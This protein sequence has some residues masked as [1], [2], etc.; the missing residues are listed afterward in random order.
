MI[1]LL[2][3]QS[4]II[5]ASGTESILLGNYEC[6]YAIGLLSKLS[7]IHVSEERNDMR[8]VQ[9]EFCTKLKGYQTTDEKE[10]QLIKILCAYKAEETYDAQMEELF[11]WGLHEEKLW[12]K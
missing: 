10:Q 9:E 12:Q 5:K 1:P 11:Q 8:R 6:A 4:V 2:A 3:R 7:G